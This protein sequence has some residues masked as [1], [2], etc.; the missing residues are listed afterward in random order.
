M[1]EYVPMSMYMSRLFDKKLTCQ[2]QPTG[3]SKHVSSFVFII[4]FEKKL[5]TGKFSSTGKYQ[6][7]DI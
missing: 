4:D 3:P 1:N 6:L 7:P 5:S 2:K